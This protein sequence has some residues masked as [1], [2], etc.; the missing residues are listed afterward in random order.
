M[1]ASDPAQSAMTTMKYGRV[2]FTRSLNSSCRCDGGTAL[3]FARRFTMVLR[4]KKAAK[5]AVNV[6]M[7]VIHAVRVF[8]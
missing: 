3:V 7:A 2:R 1:I 8:D 4:R 6:M 5:T